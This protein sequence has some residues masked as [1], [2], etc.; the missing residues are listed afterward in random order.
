MP[1]LSQL[2]YNIFAALLFIAIASA[3]LLFANYLIK[4]FRF[5]AAMLS[6]K[7]RRVILFSVIILAAY[8]LIGIIAEH[9]VPKSIS[10]QY[11]SDH[12]PA[13]NYSTVSSSHRVGLITDNGQA[14]D[15][16]LRAIENA[17]EEIIL[18]TFDFR[19]DESGRIVAVFLYRAAERGVK[20]N[21]L[22]DG[23]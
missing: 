8:I 4:P 2:T 18:S 10:S 15:L 7:L 1:A 23:F 19:D 14:L 17:E 12:D 21:I 13:G 20:V 9:A 3:A 5:T 6:V 22:T 11:A 16:R